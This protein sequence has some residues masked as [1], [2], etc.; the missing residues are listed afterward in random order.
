AVA[1]PVG[2]D[3]QGERRVLVLGSDDDELQAG[4]GHLGDGGQRRLHLGD[5]E[6]SSLARH[7]VLEAPAPPATRARLSAGARRSLDAARLLE[8]VADHAVVAT[9]GRDY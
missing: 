1:S 9:E 3:A 6:L 4:L 7:E 2:L 8:V 5:L